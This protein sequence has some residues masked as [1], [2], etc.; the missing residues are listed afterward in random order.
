MRIELKEFV[1][2]S[3]LSEDK[4][5]KWRDFRNSTNKTKQAVVKE[6][7]RF[8]QPY[9]IQESYV[10]TH[11]ETLE[12][13]NPQ[14]DDFFCEEPIIMFNGMR[15][16]CYTNCLFIEIPV[17]KGKHTNYIAA[18][19]DIHGDDARLDVSIMKKVACNPQEFIDDCLQSYKNR[20]KYYELQD[21]NNILAKKWKVK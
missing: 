12:D 11:T 19:F 9:Q 14:Y 1:K 6:L 16:Y 18:M 20:Q 3:S 8:N 5:I 17:T 4:R 2:L 7:V 10:E 15:I 13:F 21:K